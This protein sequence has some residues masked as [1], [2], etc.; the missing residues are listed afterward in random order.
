MKT[1]DYDLRTIDPED[2]AAAQE[3][4]DRVAAA[5]AQLRQAQIRRQQLD[6][7][8]HLEPAASLLQAID[9]AAQA[10]S[11]AKGEVATT[12]AHA[13]S[14][15]TAA[16]RFQATKLAA[17]QAALDAATRAVSDTLAELL[18]QAQTS[19][20]LTA[21][22]DGL[23]LRARYSTAT[24]TSPPTWNHATIP[25]RTNPSHPA[26][27]PQLR[28]P[29]VGDSDYAA[30]LAVLDLLDDQVDTVADLVTAESVHQLVQGNPARSG[31][32]LDIAATGGVPAEFEVIRSPRPSYPVTHRVLVL[33]DPQLSPVWAGSAS[34]ADS[35]ADPA[36]AAWASRLL[37][38]P[39]AVH[40]T[41]RRVDPDTNTPGEPLDLTADALGL[42]PL[43]WVRLAADPA[44]LHQRVAHAAR[45][46]WAA[47]LGEAAATG[48][49]LVDDTPAGIAA[50]ARTLADL[51]AAAAAIRELI[52]AAHALTGDDLTAPTEAV[53][54]DPA[55]AT[56][57]A[58]RVSAVEQRINEVIANLTAALPT[59][60][61]GSGNVSG[62]QPPAG[63]HGSSAEE[64]TLLVDALFAAS[65]LGEAAATPQL[66]TATP[67]LAS[68]H[69]QAATALG[70][71][72]ARISNDPFVVP[73][74]PAQTVVNARA[75]LA[76]LCGLRLPILIPVRLPAGGPW[77]DLAGEPT[78][79]LGAAPEELRAWLH[80]HASVRPAVGALLTAYDVAEALD[81]PAALDLRAT[82]LASAAPDGDP[83]RWVGADPAPPDGVVGLMVQRSFTGAVP[84]TVTGLTVDTW[85]HHIPTATLPAG[86][87]FHY[88]EPDTT[89]P[90]T[91]LVAVAPD[92]RPNRQPAT[93]DLAT[94]LDTLTATLAL[95]RDRAVSAE[96]A[97]IAG[98][99]LRDDTP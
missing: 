68:L 45:T 66:T 85:T 67:D 87:A 49:V 96:H 93:W 53:P 42:D 91:L 92:L 80:R 72:Q 10:I 97:T 69:T 39:A 20:A 79:L 24:A 76:H 82:H 75:R 4:A 29:A 19:A 84:A 99:T 51:R 58:A 7:L 61:N 13:D 70:Q 90:Q 73:D 77:Q 9:L 27:D 17:A 55:A 59:G 63:D 54:V 71:L 3:Y 48:L 22:V 41:A 8:L 57:A 28:F 40:V 83:P 1:K 21:L 86:I 14:T 5:A 25:F 34:S 36:L 38:D 6:D 2:L 52:A 30:L 89:P 37:P 11:T 46:R 74:N 88:D 64:K 15:V 32:A 56:T 23:A 33:L 44:E 47:T 35:L 95:A 65:A 78:R 12:Q 26:V 60:P 31:G 98:L 43:G 18:K 50:P 16:A 81:L 62:T 94:L